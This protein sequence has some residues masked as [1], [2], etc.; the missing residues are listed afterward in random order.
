MMALSMQMIISPEKWANAIINFSKKSYF[1]FF[2]VMSRFSIGA[3]FI[4]LPQSTYYPNFIVV[5]GTLL[6]FVSTFL[7]L[8]GSKRHQKFA[9]WSAKKFI[10]KFRIAGIFSFIF[11]LFLVYIQ[12]AFL[13]A[14]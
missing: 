11:G 3:I 13:L 7:V 1:H 14:S 12:V 8:I 2:E 10:K 5:M 9:V 4:L 6:V